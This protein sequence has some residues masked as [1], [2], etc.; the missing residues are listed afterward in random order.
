MQI[1]NCSREL[2][3]WISGGGGGGDKIPSKEK[4]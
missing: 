1:A 4:D 3:R 2:S